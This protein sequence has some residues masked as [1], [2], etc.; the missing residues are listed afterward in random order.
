MSTNIML[1][2]S[3]LLVDH[4]VHNVFKSVDTFNQS[5]EF[6]FYYPSTLLNLLEQFHSK[7]PDIQ[8]K[9]D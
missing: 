1:D 6:K 7:N 3:L 8:K 9:Y 2:P 5:T 4:S